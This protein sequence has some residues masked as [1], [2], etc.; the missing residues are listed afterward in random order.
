MIENQGKYCEVSF[1][2]ILTDVDF[3]NHSLYL[4]WEYVSM[5]LSVSNSSCIEIGQCRI[6]NAITTLQKSQQG[7]MEFFSQISYSRPNRLI[8]YNSLS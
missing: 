6:A 5:F 1:K 3:H 8:C 4:S 2:T 7:N